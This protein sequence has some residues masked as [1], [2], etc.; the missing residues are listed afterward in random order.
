MY[1]SRM[2][3]KT[4]YQIIEHKIT[5]EGVEDLFTSLNTVKTN[6]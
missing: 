5:L 6:P 1:I 2:L 3:K 4:M